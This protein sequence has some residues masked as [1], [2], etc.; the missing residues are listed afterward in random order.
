M[1]VA[2]DNS[3]EHLE[4]S[5]EIINNFY[6]D[7]YMTSYFMLLNTMLNFIKIF[8]LRNWSTNS[9]ELLEKISPPDRANSSEMII[10]Q[11]ETVKTLGLLFNT[12]TD[13]FQYSVCFEKIAGVITN[14][15]VLMRNEN[16]HAET[17]D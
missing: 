10:D 5:N 11:S 15:R 9:R 3:H 4:E 8:N 13:C 17:L 1:H 6:V 16:L 7:N 14:R 2:L 12:S